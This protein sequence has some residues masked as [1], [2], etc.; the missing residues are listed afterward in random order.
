MGLALLLVAVEQVFRGFAL[1]HGSQ[2][3]SQ[4]VRISYADVHALPGKWRGQVGGVS[5]QQHLAH[6][7]TI[8]HARMK[9]VHHFA[10]N[11]Q[12]RVFWVAVMNPLP[13]QRFLQT[14]VGVFAGV[15]HEFIA[16]RGLRAR[17]P[18]G[19]THRIAIGAG[20][21][22]SGVAANQVGNE[23]FFG[24]RAAVEADAQLLAHAAAPAVTPH[25]PSGLHLQLLALVAQSQV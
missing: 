1:H 13:H 23:P 25:Q 2:L 12:L 3:P 20:M 6:P 15:Q 17:E 4:V 21:P 8:G 11:L 5:S 18:N 24:V 10:Q 19:R 16:H 14:S 7:P 22:K 9:G